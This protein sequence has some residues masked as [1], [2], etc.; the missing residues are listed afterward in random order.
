MYVGL[1]LVPWF[2]MYA[3]GTIGL[4]HRA[5]F[6][7]IYQDEGVKFAVER[8][9]AYPRAF[10]A[11]APLRSISE[12]ILKDLGMEGAHGV[13]RGDDGEIIVNRG[14]AVFPRRI[15]YYP[16]ENQLIVEKQVFRTMDFFS[17]LHTRTGYS[18]QYKINSAWAAS[19]DLSI[20]AT[21]FWIFSGLWLWWE[22]KNTRRLGGYF[23]ILGLV[24]FGLFVI[25]N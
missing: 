4:N 5:L 13:R 16:D 19:V 1:F 18:N 14:Y 15:T 3:L 10:A 6:A 20:A 9:V 12:Q 23:T 25:A 11:D 22:M 2:L 21:F 24:L 17:R 7:K 8:E